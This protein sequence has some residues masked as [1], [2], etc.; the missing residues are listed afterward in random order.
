MKKYLAYLC[1]ALTIIL[2][3]GLTIQQIYAHNLTAVYNEDDSVAELEPTSLSEQS[4][5]ADEIALIDDQQEEFYVS[6][7]PR[8]RFYVGSDYFYI[9]DTSQGGVLLALSQYENGSEMVRLY[10]F[11]IYAHTYL[12][13]Y[14]ERDFIEEYYVVKNQWLDAMGSGVFCD[15]IV[16]S[17]QMML[18]EESWAIDIAFPLQHPFMLTSDEFV[19][20][21][22]YF[23]EANPQFYLNQIVP[24]TMH[25]EEGLTPFISI[26]AY[27]AFA[28]RR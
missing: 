4:N 20:V 11:L 27:Y 18:D 6:E 23:S 28:S 25:S 22:F 13:L 17:L 12:M 8:M 24:M 1:I 2:L 19:R 15:E 3:G 26:P 5:S 10:E 14:D 7:T 9:V 21:Y 16:E